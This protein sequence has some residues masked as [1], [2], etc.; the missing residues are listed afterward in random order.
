MLNV[1]EK[2]AK[3]RPEGVYLIA[4]PNAGVPKLVDG[5]TVFDA[6]PE[7]MAE[8]AERYVKLGVNIV[9]ACCGSTPAHIKA[10]RERVKK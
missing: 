5:K 6:T 1:V 2:M 7:K 9:G 8:Y 4:Q 3:S 10:I